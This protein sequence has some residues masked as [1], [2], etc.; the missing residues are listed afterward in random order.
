MH[1]AILPDGNANFSSKINFCWVMPLRILQTS[2]QIT[3]LLQLILLS[4]AAHTALAGARVT[5]SLYALS[6][7]ASEFT[8][9]VL[10]ALFSLFPMLF[11][12]PMGRL[13]DRIGLQRPV[14]FGCSAMAVGC[15]LP[16]LVPGLP[17]LY[18]AVVLIGTGFM[19]TQVASQHTVGAMSGAQ[20]RAGNFGWLALGYSISSFSGPVIAGFMIDH[21]SFRSAFAILLGFV[22]CAWLLIVFGSVKTIRVRAPADI[23]TAGKALDLLRNPNLRRI[24]VVGILL[25][26]AWDL[27]IF[28]MPIQGT[29]LGFSASTIGLILGSFSAATFAIRLV[30]PWIVRHH[31]EWRILAAALALSVI[32]YMLVPFMQTPH[33]L[34]GV[35]AALGLAVG[36]SQSNVLTLLHH[37]SPAGRAGE[38]VG[39]RTTIGNACQV[40]LPLAFGAV[41]AAVGLFAVFWGLGIIISL[42]V[43]L[44]WRQA[45]KI[46]S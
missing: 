25:T 4:V 32:C 10:I 9:G 11:A 44:A 5:T 26:A 22:L 14:S 39:M 19:A 23:P 16:V 35:A 8:V 13:I 12:V 17:I 46:S 34:M 40:G 43:P 18:F 29:R 1:A 24:F 37:F 41:G 30:M 28:V 27:F 6:L 20:A 33:A 2:P 15:A 38:A 45:S 42:G 31:S 3:H 7:H 36:S 21:A